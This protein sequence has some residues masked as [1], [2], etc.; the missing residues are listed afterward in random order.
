MSRRFR[1]FLRADEAVSALEY[2]MLVGII[3]VAVM[4]AVITFSGKYKA[5]ITAVAAKVGAIT[6]PAIRITP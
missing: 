6:T 4:A 3:A 5:P 2:A 1:L